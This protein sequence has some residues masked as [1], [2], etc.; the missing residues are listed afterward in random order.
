MSLT[1]RAAWMVLACTHTGAVILATA[2][3][4]GPEATQHMVNAVVVGIVVTIIFWKIEK[5]RL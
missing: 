3:L 2:F 5:K 4:V 1:E